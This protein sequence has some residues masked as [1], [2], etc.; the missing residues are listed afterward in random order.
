MHALVLFA[1]LAALVALDSSLDIETP[2]N[3]G[4]AAKRRLPHP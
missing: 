4:D 2:P 3:E 1:L